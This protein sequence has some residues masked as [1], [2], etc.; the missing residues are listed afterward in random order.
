MN[1][2]YSAAFALAVPLLALSIT[3]CGGGATGPKPS[4]SV[5]D[6][7]P[8]S[9]LVADADTALATG[10]AEGARRLLARAVQAAPE[11]A[12]V[13]LA[14]GR[15]W[16]AAHRYKDAKDAFERAAALAPSSPEPP[17]ELGR[18][19]Q[20][21]GDLTEAARAYTAALRL[22]PNHAA[23]A[24]ALGPILGARYEAAGIPGEYAL[25]RGRTTVSRG[26]LAVILAVELGADPTAVTWRSTAPPSRREDQELETAWGSRW[27]RAAATRDWIEPFAD[28]SYHLDDPVTRAA[29]AITLADVERKWAAPGALGMGRGAEPA[30]SA[31]LNRAYPDLGPRH[32]LARVAARAALDGLPAREDGGFDPWAAAS[33]ADILTAS[34]GLARRLGASPVVSAEPGAPGMVK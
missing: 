33:G 6:H 26:E 10:D 3:G 12:F 24:A 27:A 14:Y 9:A 2:S 29:L 7:T 21:A 19:Y 17:Y 11:S 25:L 8:A 34:R 30:D 22:D 1:R 4:A 23:S 31:S 5:S 18:A 20:Q 13:H 28:G 15:Y 16:T 32:Y